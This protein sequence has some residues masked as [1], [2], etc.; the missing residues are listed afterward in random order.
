MKQEICKTHRDNTASRG[1]IIAFTRK[2]YIVIEY[3]WGSRY[4]VDHLEARIVW[5]VRIPYH[6]AA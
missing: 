4:T 5:K 1:G 3:V 6:M 2:D